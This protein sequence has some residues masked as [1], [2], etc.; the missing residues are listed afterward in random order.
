MPHNNIVSISIDSLDASMYEGI[1]VDVVFT[2][3]FLAKK[4]F[5]DDPAPLDPDL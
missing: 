1:L 5:L 4:N 3:F 2:G